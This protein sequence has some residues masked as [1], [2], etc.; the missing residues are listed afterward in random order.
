MADIKIS[1]LPAG[2][3]PAGTEEV[4]LVQGG[5]TK[6]V[7]VSQILAGTPADKV[8]SVDTRTGDVTLSDRYVS[9]TGGS[10]SGS[11]NVNSFVAVGANAAQTGAIRLANSAGLS[12]R[13]AANTADVNLVSISSTDVVQVGTGPA[14]T[15]LASNTF[16]RVIINGIKQLEFTTTGVNLTDGL[17]FNCGTTLG[18]RIGTAAT[19]KLGFY[20]ATP[21]VRATGTPAAATDPATTM[22]LVNDLRAKLIALGLIS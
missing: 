11:L 17:V 18:N 15:Q 22:A 13:N 16:V 1:A 10:V 5:I 21:V 2:T 8:T 6:K 3:T 20:G 14:T 9:V 12:A 4:P 19:Q 7:T